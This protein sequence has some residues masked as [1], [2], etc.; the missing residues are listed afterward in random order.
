MV[1]RPLTAA[2]AMGEIGRPASVKGEK[3]GPASVFSDI[4]DVVTLGNRSGGDS[5]LYNARPLFKIMGAVE[6]MSGDDGAWDE[7]GFG[8]H[9]VML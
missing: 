3:S 2:Y 5:G 1:I 6:L 7:V 4:G 8:D 9:P